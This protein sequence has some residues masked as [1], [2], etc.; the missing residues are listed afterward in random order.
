MAG[1]FEVEF[2]KNDA[3][4]MTCNVCLYTLKEPMQSEK[5]GHRFCRE[6]VKLLPK[7]Y[8]KSSLFLHSS[9]SNFSPHILH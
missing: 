6:C 5:C 2:V 1:G 4:N 3:K 7:E 9:S 8:D